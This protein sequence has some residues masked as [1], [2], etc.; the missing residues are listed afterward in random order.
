MPEVK[1]WS[2]EGDVSDNYDALLDEVRREN[3]IHSNHF[4][5]LVVMDY[6]HV[7][8]VFADTENF[9]NFDFAARFKFISSLSGDDPLLLDFAANLKYWLLFM[10]GPEHIEQRKFVHKKFYEADY[11]QITNDSIRELIDLYR[12]REK[13]DLVEISRHFSFLIISKII[14]LSERDFDFIQKFAY[15]ITMI[16]EKTLSIRDLKECADLSK[17]FSGYMR[18]TLDRHERQET[19]SLLIDMKRIIGEDDAHRLIATWEFLVNAAVETTALLVAGSVTTL[20]ENKEKKID[21][22]SKTETA[23][24]VE[25]LI[26]YVSPIK[27]IPRQ[28]V[29]DMVYEGVKVR[30]GQTAF[31]CIA[32]ANRDPAVFEDPQEFIPTRKPNQ[33]V[34]FGYGVHH[35]LG[36]RLSR[37]EMQKLLPRFMESFPDIRFD[38]SVERE[39]DNKFFFRGFKKLPVLLK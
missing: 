17:E 21:W 18:E 14:D 28:V 12:D 10:N 25:E 11:E 26:R 5:D 27:W 8:S 19:E 31:V 30:K 6:D 39:W 29:E 23:I 24:A 32:S 35:C 7:K 4:G 13:A 3:P 1:I 36:A 2:V 20:I 37:F 9:S 22:T 38:D 15:I 34:G 16:F 33:H